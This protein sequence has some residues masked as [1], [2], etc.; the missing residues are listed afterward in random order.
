MEQGAQPC[1]LPGRFNKTSSLQTLKLLSTFWNS[2]ANTPCHWTGKLTLWD[3]YIYRCHRGYTL[4]LNK[5]TRFCS[6]KYVSFPGKSPQ[7]APIVSYSPVD[8]R[9]TDFCI[10]LRG[11]DYIMGLLLTLFFT[12]DKE[13][14]HI[15]LLNQSE[16]SKINSFFLKSFL[17]RAYQSKLQITEWKNQTNRSHCFLARPCN[18]GWH[19]NFQNWSQSVCPMPPPC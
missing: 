15:S 2:L 4:K 6:R 13:V 14:L 5:Y 1:H 8:C 16:V 3:Q 19:A 18:D 9:N 12:S 17:N 10:F 11:T 7:V